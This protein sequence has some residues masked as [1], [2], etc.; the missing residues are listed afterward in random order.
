MI[1]VKARRRKKVRARS[2]SARCDRCAARGRCRM[3]SNR[4]TA[5]A[6]L[7]PI[8]AAVRHRN[9]VQHRG[10]AIE[11][12]VQFRE[13]N[14]DEVHIAYRDDRAGKISSIRFH[15]CFNHWTTNNCTWL[16]FNDILT[17]GKTSDP[18]AFCGGITVFHSAASRRFLR[19]I[20]VIAAPAGLRCRTGV[21]D[22]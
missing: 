12:A 8:A 4:M 11:S 21:C 1:C 10:T 16:P 22:V 13:R 3:P 19:T 2:R 18:L 15:G 6:S 7:S 14:C 17:T 20:R 5:C 9:I